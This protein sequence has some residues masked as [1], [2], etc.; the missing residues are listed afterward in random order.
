[1]KVPKR[2]RK[3]GS[4]G[5]VRKSAPKVHRVRRAGISKHTHV[6]SKTA[7]KAVLKTKMLAHDKTEHAKKVE[8]A[9]KVS[10][11][12]PDSSEAK[13]AIDALM[14][15][16]GG[17]TYLKKNVSRSVADVIGML[18]V[19][20]TDEYIAEK[21]NIK[22]NA[23]RRMLNIMQNYGITNYYISKNKN[24]WLS[25]AWYMNTSKLPT[26]LEYVRGVESE[27]SMIEENCNDYFVC[28]N[29]YKENKLIFTFDAAYE[30]GFSCNACGKNLERL[31]GKSDVERLLNESAQDTKITSPDELM[32][33]RVG[34]K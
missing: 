27:K 18:T 22:I 34:Q 10:M 26:F 11:G 17:M 15:N 1:M 7:G 32:K 16:E 30:A 31:G 25:F 14:Q 2:A 21:L 12:L 5:K 33:A 6:R 28:N 3:T 13:G 8:A 29:C 19:P 4:K 23:V 20:R 24:G 9:K